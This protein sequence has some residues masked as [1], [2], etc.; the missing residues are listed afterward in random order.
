MNTPSQTD[1]A[2]TSIIVLLSSAQKQAIDSLV[3][4]MEEGGAIMAQVY[5]DGM[6]VTVLSKQQTESV[7]NALGT[8]DTGLHTSVFRDHEA[9]NKGQA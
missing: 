8:P 5:G 2:S 7:R 1:A 4:K 6:R 9:Y 3:H